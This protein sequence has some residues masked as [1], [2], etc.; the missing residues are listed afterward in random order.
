M[1]HTAPPP[2][3]APDPSRS[4]QAAGTLTRESAW[5][6]ANY[7]PTMAAAPADA[8][9]LPLAILAKEQVMAAVAEIAPE[10]Y[11]ART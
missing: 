9:G 8:E 11:R 6:S 1:T 4:H 10:G 7:I 5:R 3:T 2:R